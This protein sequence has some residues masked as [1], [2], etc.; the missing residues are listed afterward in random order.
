MV[1]RSIFY[2][3]E[4]TKSSKYFEKCPEMT[5]KHD[6]KEDALSSLQSSKKNSSTW[7]LK[8]REEF[9]QSLSQDEIQRRGGLKK[10][11]QQPTNRYFKRKKLSDIVMV[12]GSSTDAEKDS[13]SLFCHFLNGKLCIMNIDIFLRCFIFCS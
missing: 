3:L 2:Y 7:R 10:L 4:R 1:K 12:H 8:T 13:L 11:E 6:L 9:I 5:Q